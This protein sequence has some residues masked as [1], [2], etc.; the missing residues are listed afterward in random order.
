MLSVCPHF[1]VLNQLIDFH[2]ICLE[3]YDPQCHNK[4]NPDSLVTILTELSR[5]LTGVPCNGTTR[6]TVCEIP[7]RNRT[8][9]AVVRVALQ[10]HAVT[11]ASVSASCCGW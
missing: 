10:Q 5:F 8:H 6:S 4:S 9:R 2:A 3:F 7:S 11:V 1:Q